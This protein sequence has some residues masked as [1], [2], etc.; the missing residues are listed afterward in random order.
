MTTTPAPV[1]APAPVSGGAVRQSVRRGRFWIVLG[2]ILIAVVVIMLVLRGGAPE[3][4]TPLAADNPAPQGGKAVAQVLSRRGVQVHIAGSLKSATAQSAGATV[5]LYDPNGYLDDEQL[6]GLGET[7]GALVIVEPGFETL[8]ALVPGLRL[9]GTPR[10]G[11]FSA[12]CTQGAA[13]RAG[14]I[15]AATAA[16]RPSNASQTGCFPTGDG[17]YAMIV[18]HA[19]AGTV[20]VLGSRAVFANESVIRRGNAALALGV[21]GGRADLVWYLPTAADVAASGPPS[22]AEL[23]PGWVTPAVLLLLAVFGA[24]AVWRGR[25]FGPLVIE[26]LPVVVRAEETMEGRSRLYQRSSARLRALDALRIGSIGRIAALAGLPS[27]AGMATVVSA[28]AT[29]TARSPAEVERILVDAVPRSDRE[30]MALARELDAVEAAVR[31]ATRSATGSGTEHP[32]G[33]MAQ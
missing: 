19:A 18:S 31:S 25:R 9:A 2:G 30:L 21:L 26:N 17:A 13:A 12:R 22:L 1:P 23:T 33:R 20:T 28:A 14:S 27:N 5:L 3:A 15:S 29:L 7:A 24:A 4:G 6:R 8:R 11:A 10:A 16:Y 32:N